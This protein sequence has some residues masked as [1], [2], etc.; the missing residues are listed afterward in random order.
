[1]TARV[2]IADDDPDVLDLMS[3]LLNEEGFETIAF[4]DGLAALHAIRTERPALA[5]I[6]LAM[7]VIDGPELIRRLR[8]EAEDHLPIIALSAA[9]YTPPEDLLLADAAISKPFDLEELLEHVHHLA[10]R[11]DHSAGQV[12]EAQASL[13]PLRSSIPGTH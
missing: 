6:D 7:P 12:V 11:Q 10:S 2:L 3:A 9:I 4:T 8:Q 5:I 13:L 1:M